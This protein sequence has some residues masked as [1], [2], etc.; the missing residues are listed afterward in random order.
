M[1]AAAV[2]AAGAREPVHALRIS[3]LCKSFGGLVVLSDL[4][5]SIP[6]RAGTAVAVLGQN[7]AGKTT[8]LNLITRLL[9]IDAGVIEVHGTDV[10]SLPRRALPGH[11]IGRTFQS[12]RLLI[13]DTVMDN[14]LLGAVTHGKWRGGGRRAHLEKAEAALEQ[15]GLQD[16][17]GRPVRSLPFGSRKLVELARALA[18]DPS[19]L[20]L[21]EPAAGL[22]QVEEERLGQILVRLREAGVILLLIEHRMMLVTSVARRVVM[23]DSG[24]IVFDGRVQD[25]LDSAVVRDGY[26]GTKVDGP[27]VG[28]K[29]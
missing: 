8:L 3:G 23:M 22:S 14:V 9:P 2:A 7:G 21:D 26:L 5:L 10:A 13:E 28:G 16:L 25:A 6:C 29:R 18:G 17:A 20:L 1:S 24:R 27:P 11:G 19:L 12:P 4:E 15:V